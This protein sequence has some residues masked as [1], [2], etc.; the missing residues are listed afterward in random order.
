MHELT[1]LK[2]LFSKI[3]SIAD[4]NRSN[5]VINVTVKLGPLSHIS[6]DHLRG[7]FDQAAVGT[8]AEG[9]SL[10]IRELTDM[11]DPHAQEIILESIEV[12]QE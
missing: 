5:K 4:E 6:P 8:V 10:T 11:S 7:H 12:A 3:E 2:D 1:L 9:A